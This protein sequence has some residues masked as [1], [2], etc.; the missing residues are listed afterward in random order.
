M[1]NAIEK[2][3]AAAMSKTEPKVCSV[4][5]VKIVAMIGGDRVL[6]SSGSPG[7]RDTLWTKVCQYTQ[8]PGCINQP[9]DRNLPK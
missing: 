5:G 1:S 6:F 2:W 8:K 7:N 3:E 4:C 9:K